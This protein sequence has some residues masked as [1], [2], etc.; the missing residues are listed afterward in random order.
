MKNVQRQKRR[1]I[2]SKKTVS[3]KKKI[4]QVNTSSKKKIV[5]INHSNYN[6][7]NENLITA[8]QLMK[9]NEKN[10]AKKQRIEETESETTVIQEDSDYKTNDF[11]ENIFQESKRSNSKRKASNNPRRSRISSSG[12]KLVIEEM[13]KS[14]FNQSHFSRSPKKHNY[15]IQTKNE[16][17]KEIDFSIQ[18]SEKKNKEYINSLEEKL[19]ECVRNGEYI[20]ADMIN[21]EIKEVKK[22][23]SKEL[24]KTLENEIGRGNKLLE[25]SIRSEELEI[26][27]KFDDL[28]E[29]ILNDFETQIEK[30][31]QKHEQEKKY[32][33]EQFD[34][35]QLEDR[36]KYFKK[37]SKLLLMEEEIKGLLNNRQ[38][39]LAENL[40]NK[41]SLQLN[42]EVELFKEKEE[43]KLQ[44]KIKLMDTKFQ[45][46]IS[47]I[48]QRLHS[49]INELTIAFIEQKN[50]LIKRK[51]SLQLTFK[52]KEI[53][54]LNRIPISKE[55]RKEIQNF[56]NH[57][58]KKDPFKNSRFRKTLLNKE[59][60][61]EIE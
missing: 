52:N 38:Y 36:E 33:I 58:I 20:K 55:S 30:L 51:K 23:F 24:V 5:E 46:E 6:Q 60:C 53:S 43:L 49:A 45:T 47:S 17:V 16:H 11:K 37:S 44:N 12:K 54:K 28:K 13:K 56:R 10:S 41:I 19:K 25:E 15:F 22:R 29:R 61:F 59:N 27:N 2:S 3:N 18:S 9:Q 4:K 32:L 21:K 57:L 35:V 40:K 8:S 48:E 39:L 31:K 14:Y 1:D 7:E 50:N 42:D 26:Q 34:Q